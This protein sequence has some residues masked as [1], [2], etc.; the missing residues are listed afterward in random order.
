MYVCVEQDA[1]TTQKISHMEGTWL[2]GID[3]DDVRYWDIQKL[4]LA[5]KVDAVPLPDGEALLS[6]SR[7][8]ED[9]RFLREND[10][11]KSSEY[12]TAAALPLTR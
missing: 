12:V 8:R 6:D 5:Q 3:F 9:L 11:D 2:G 4:G 7:Y 1:G 10:L